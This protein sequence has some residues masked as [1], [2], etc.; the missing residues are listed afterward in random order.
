[1]E[2]YDLTRYKQ[3]HELVYETAL[4]EI[5][6]GKKETHWMWYI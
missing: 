6:N 1:M 2:K 3:A 5:K 4:G